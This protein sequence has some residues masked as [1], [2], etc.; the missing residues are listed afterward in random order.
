MIQDCNI[1]C[2][3]SAHVLE[4]D[5][6]TKLEGI[7]PGIRTPF[8]QPFVITSYSDEG[9]FTNPIADALLFD[10][11]EP[12]QYGCQICG[13][14]ADQ[15]DIIKLFCD[16]INP[17]KGIDKRPER[18]VVTVESEVKPFKQFLNEAREK[19][20]FDTFMT[21]L[22]N[23]DG[24]CSADGG[25]H[26]FYCLKLNDDNFDFD[27]YD[28]FKE[29][30]EKEGLYD[31][32]WVAGIIPN[33]N[34]KDGKVPVSWLPIFGDSNRYVTKWLQNGTPSSA[35][36]EVFRDRRMKVKD[37]I[38]YFAIPA[39][40]Q[41][42]LNTLKEELEKIGLPCRI[43][44]N[45]KGDFIETNL[46]FSQEACMRMHEIPVSSGYKIVW[47]IRNKFVINK[48]KFNSVQ[49]VVDYF[50]EN[51]ELYEILEA[52]EINKKKEFGMKKLTEAMLVLERAGLL[53]EEYPGEGYKKPVLQMLQEIEDNDRDLGKLVDFIIKD[54]WSD[55][56]K[57]FND[58]SSEFLEI[59]SDT[60]YRGDKY[61]AA[62]FKEGFAQ[63]SRD[64]RG[65]G[66]YIFSK[67][68]KLAG[69]PIK[70]SKEGGA[71]K[72]GAWTQAWCIDFNILTNDDGSYDLKA[73]AEVV[74]NDDKYWEILDELYAHRKDRHVSHT[75][76]E[77]EKSIESARETSTLKALNSISRAP[78]TKKD[79]ERFN[80]ST[81]GRQLG[82]LDN[83]SEEKL[84]SR[85]HAILLMMAK[86][87][88]GSIGDDD[89][90]F[91]NERVSITKV[92]RFLRRCGIS[93]PDARTYRELGSIILG[94]LREIRDY[95]KDELEVLEQ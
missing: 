19:K 89:I 88:D 50:K 72:R 32:S 22:M 70:F 86:K 29:Q 74:G 7:D 33:K 36:A 60:S 82:T 11:E 69:I 81:I 59:K 62:W 14:Y 77:E 47:L 67:V 31:W 49:K 87:Y 90:Y 40:E 52:K 37:R 80:S 76:S 64:A 41:L 21:Y 12:T 34:L 25:D 92:S 9:P 8:G 1:P 53:V 95:F 93:I 44:N 13:H 45:R 63:N 18:E 68:S 43:G 15:E 58:A 6:G 55:I 35:V 3:Y 2:K 23:Q 75:P 54:K 73:I 78:M 79:W 61:Y 26:T 71:R 84:N 5:D 17:L 51:K 57:A 10:E 16:D 46:E 91:G 30:I 66:R 85:K 39:E 94:R 65:Y 24:R 27:G 28:K 4:F 83:L 56:Q 48:H 42:S 20:T 38:D